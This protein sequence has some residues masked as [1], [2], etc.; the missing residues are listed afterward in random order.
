MVLQPSMSETFNYV[1]IEAGAVGRPWVG[2]AAIR[3]TPDGW[4]ADPNDPADI[5]RVSQWLL[6]NY[7]D[8]SWQARQIAEQVTRRNNA[9]YAEMVREILE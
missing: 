5:A 9:A 8:A 2:S 4:Q 3:H 6:A 7:A 1:S